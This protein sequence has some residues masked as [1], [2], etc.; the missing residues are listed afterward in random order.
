LNKNMQ[1]F[2]FNTKYNQFEGTGR[3]LSTHTVI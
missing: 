1:S 3:L 2:F